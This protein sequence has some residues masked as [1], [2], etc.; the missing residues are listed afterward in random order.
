RSRNAAHALTGSVRR[1]SGRV[2][3]TAQLTRAEDGMVVWSDSYDRAEA[4]MIGIQEEIAFAIAQALRSV[5][6]PETLRKM[7]ETGTR[8]VEAYEALLTGHYLLNQQ[9]LTGDASFRRRAY[10]SY[11][12]AR[13]TDPT[14]S[15]AHWLAARYWMERATYIIP[16]GEEAEYSVQEISE[17]FLERVDAAI[18]TE[19]DGVARQKYIAARHEHRLE[20]RAAH[21]RLKA[22]VEARPNDPY[23][24][25]QL[26]GTSAVVGDF[27]TGRMAALR[28]DELSE[29][30]A[31]YLSRATVVHLWVRDFD[32]SLA[33]A[34]RSLSQAPGNAFVRYHAHR[35]FLWAGEIDAARELVGPIDAGA[36]SAH[37]RLLVQLRQSCAERDYEAARST[38]DA[39]SATSNASRASLW[40]GAVL[41]GEYDTARSLLA[42]LDTPQG[43]NQLAA[44]T[45]YPQFASAEF[46]QL[47]QKFLTEGI[48]RAGP[49]FPPYACFQPSE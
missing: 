36:L 41:M 31:L 12:K 22:Y 19:T 46:D 5:L 21:E 26:A 33:Q 43:L 7:V 29:R 38:Y 17:W 15:A 3:V 23:A 2:R 49:I 24:W 18:A 4:D 30:N 8:S 45:K 37:N 32:G 28:L 44:F 20:F 39:L 10:E 1:A 42:G 35:A 48:E 14:F 40:L 9:Y 13:A 27:E 16:P 6:D 11:E 47:E 34:K 25:V